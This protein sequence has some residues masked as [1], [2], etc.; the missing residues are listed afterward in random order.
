MFLK[1][2]AEIKDI[3]RA[4]DI[5]PKCSTYHYSDHCADLAQLTH[6]RLR[7]H[8]IECSAKLKA[9]GRITFWGKKYS[10]LHIWKK[11]VLG[12]WRQ[13]VQD[14]PIFENEF[15]GGYIRQITH[16]TVYVVL[17]TGSIT[18]NTVTL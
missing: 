15:S 18:R 11:H 16:K 5:I 10:T 14:C 8:N 4:P 13:E 3:L 17:H 7:K 1:L 9:V 2:R 6:W 12:I